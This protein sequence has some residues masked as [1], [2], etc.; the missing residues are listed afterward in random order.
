MSATGD[1]VVLKKTNLVYNYTKTTGRNAQRKTVP[2]QDNNVKVIYSV[3]NK[4][5][6]VTVYQDDGRNLS[7]QTTKSLQGLEL[8]VWTPT[9]G[10]GGEWYAIGQSGKTI[11]TK[12]PVDPTWDQLSGDLYTTGLTNGNKLISLVKEDVK[13]LPVK[14]KQNVIGVPGV[15]PVESV[16]E[17]SGTEGSEEEN[18]SKPTVEP[19]KETFGVRKD[20][21][22]LTYPKEIPLNVQDIIKFEIV[23]YK[24]LSFSKT[25]SGSQVQDAGAP[26]TL[27]TGAKQRIKQDAI[28]S[29]SLAI[30]PPV[31]DTNGV[32]W[33]D[34]GI[35]LVQLGVASLS[36]GFIENGFGGAQDAAGRLVDRTKADSGT[37]KSALEKYFAGK[38]AQA[39]NLLS[40]LTGSVLNPNLETLFE[41]PRT[42]T[43][44]YQFQ[45]TPRD[46]EEAV[47]VRK[48]I[49]TFKEAMAIQRTKGLSFLK[50]P[51]VFRIRYLYKGGEDH[52]YI[53]RVKGPCALKDL[54][55]DYTP[56]GSYMT[57]EG[58][59][60]GGSMVKYTITMVF[61]ELDP[62]Y[63]DDYERLGDKTIIG[64]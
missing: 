63:A 3:N 52:P 5:G 25:T 48:I 46:E 62:I 61:Q 41:G 9:K 14:D 43:F 50:A 57:Y 34:T 20:F 45:F 11:P 55:T 49:R 21:E 22:S 16:D 32:N 17:T 6:S 10:G 60:D 12:A 42:R 44:N 36:L 15:P 30:Q 23:E 7:G 51:Y 27:F 54:Q 64:Y 56:E 26:T 19:E 4:T 35:N 58:D 38:A 24:T 18:D 1:L 47:E 40:R 8:A 33:T 28:G 37:I 39:N 59:K 2:A 13:A 29:I 53:G 31:T